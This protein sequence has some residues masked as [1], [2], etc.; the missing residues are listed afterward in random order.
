MGLRLVN[1]KTSQ[2]RSIKFLF[3]HH[4]TKSLMDHIIL[5]WK[6]R[7]LGCQNPRVEETS[8]KNNFLLIYA[9]E[10]RSPLANSC[11]TRIAT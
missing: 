7:F 5:S 3:I 6:V 11:M 8:T 1:N 2:N 4:Q 10:F 9:F